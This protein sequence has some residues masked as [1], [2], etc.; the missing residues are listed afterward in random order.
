MAA[1][2]LT[3]WWTFRTKTSKNYEN[4]AKTSE[5]VGENSENGKKTMVTLKK[6]W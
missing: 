2:N 6:M 3:G 5:N 1:L 4:V